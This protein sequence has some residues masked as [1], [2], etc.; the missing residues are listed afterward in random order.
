[1]PLNEDTIITGLP[2]LL[3]PTEKQESPGIVEVATAAFRRENSIVGLWRKLNEPD[4][5]A[6][7]EDD[8][9]DPF[10]DIDG[11]V[12]ESYPEA[13]IG[14]RSEEEKAFKLQKIEQEV[15]DLRTIADAGPLGFAATLA[16]GFLDP[17]VLVPF[18]TSAR[19]ARAAKATLGIAEEAAAGFIRGGIITARASAFG[20]TAA[21]LA[22]QAEQ[23]SRTLGESALNVSSAAVLGGLLGGGITALTTAE[24]VAFAKSI[25]KDFNVVAGGSGEAPRIRL[26]ELAEDAATGGEKT[27]IR[28]KKAFGIERFL[29]KLHTS[30][31][32]RL[33]VRSRSQ[34]AKRIAMELADQ[35]FIV[36][37]F[38]GGRS[39]E[40]NV[41]AYDVVRGILAQE[42]DRLYTQYR[43]RVSGTRQGGRAARFMT[44]FWDRFRDKGHAYSK[45]EFLEM[46][47]ISGRT[48]DIEG[49]TPQGRAIIPPEASEL[50]K[51]H[52]KLVYEPL[53]KRMVEQGRLPA[54]VLEKGPKFAESYLS[55]RYLREKILQETDIAGNSTFRKRLKIW[56]REKLDNEEIERIE[57]ANPELMREAAIERELEIAARSIEE[58]ITGLSAGRLLYERPSVGKQGPIKERALDFDDEFMLDFLD[59]NI[60]N[61]TDSYLRTVLPDIE[62]TERFGSAEMEGQI[63]A[64]VTEYDG[65][66]AAEKNPKK[67]AKIVD[68]MKE[69]L[70]I[71]EALRDR[72]RNK[73]AVPPDSKWVTAARVV[74]T[75]NMTAQGGS[76]VVSSVP[77]IAMPVLRNGLIRTMRAT[78]TPLLTDLKAL[79]LAAAEVKRAGSAWEI[80]LDT[81]AHAMA[82]IGDEFARN[83]TELAAKSVASNFSLIN[84]LSPWNSMMKQWAG[85][86][87]QTKLIEIIEAL[88]D[89][90]KLRRVDAEDLLQVRISDSMARRIAKELQGPEGSVKRSGLAWA[91]TSDWRDLEAI[92]AF[93]SAIRQSV[94]NTIITPGIGDRPL[95]MSRELG[96]TLFQYKSFALASTQRL[97]LTNL[98]RRDL[99]TMNGLIIATSLGM[100]VEA[101]KTLNAGRELPKDVDRFIW[102][103]VDRSGMIGILGD[104]GNIAGRLGY[105][106]VAGGPLSSR[107]ASRNT[108]SSILGPTAGLVQAGLRITAATKEG[109]AEG[110]IRA[111]RR[112]IPY[113]NLFYF[114]KLLDQVEQDFNEAAGIPRTRRRQ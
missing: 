76:F 111:M 88:A 22:L 112:L 56:L 72:L 39:V 1:M 30:P 107:Y 23:E 92:A 114:R 49:I 52:R 27:E 106:P 15:A 79:K 14:V 9:Y 67:R 65:I 80:V 34:E 32:L 66:R 87:Q 101:F 99:A 74:R 90:K 5:P 77:D 4:F 46:A 73:Y 104:F 57:K 85:V 97:L 60:E 102:A 48:G 75:L 41:L 86:V 89:G 93:R 91:N 94:D 110:D 45:R 25:A 28:V 70:K 38:E 31:M 105:G 64:I 13:L 50:A 18:G 33:M 59:N 100:F 42:G 17:I 40:S 63:D 69:D 10:D 62:L 19:T 11:T 103:G 84:L 35:G 21:E 113:Q 16:A 54:E 98:Q 109:F 7:E 6:L 44:E 47:G 82:D 96:K 24:R 78:A 81:R 8:S 71:I 55:R 26:N 36:E 20:A 61:V 58:H 3:A 51:L 29:A 12:F 43:N 53:A 108:F 95:F 83:R 2:V 37:G 68:Q